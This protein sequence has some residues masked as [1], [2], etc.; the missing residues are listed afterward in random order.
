[1]AGTRRRGEL[2]LADDRHKLAQ[3]ALT[4]PGASSTELAV[5]FEQEY[6]IAIPARTVR[7]DLQQLKKQWVTETKRDMEIVRA[8]ELARVDALEQA[9]WTAWR[10][11]LQPFNK[12][13][14]ERLH[15][16]IN[17]AARAKLAGEIASELAESNEYVTEEVMEAIVRDAIADSIDQGEDAE[18]FVNKVTETTEVR[19]GD[20]RFLSQIHEIQKERRK[21]LGVYAPELHQIDVRKI[22]L[23]GYAG[24]WSPDEWRDDDIIEG[25]FDSGE[26]A[27]E[28]AKALLSGGSDEEE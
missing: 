10:A 11:S 22:E 8:Q 26:Q 9:A 4:N 16:A 1:M 5:L 7:Y 17:D 13:V 12:V 18:T 23:K 19:I 3:L 15:K 2:E 24:G 20:P 27:A 21:I 25:D 28:D 14:V 6:G